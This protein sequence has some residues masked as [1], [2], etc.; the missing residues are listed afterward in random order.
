MR[1]N[2]TVDIEVMEYV[3]IE[4]NVLSNNDSTVHFN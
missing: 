3:S 4:V 1:A 2:V